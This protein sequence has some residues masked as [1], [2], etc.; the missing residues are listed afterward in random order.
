[1]LTMQVWQV[2][3]TRGKAGKKKWGRNDKTGKKMKGQGEG[4]V[5][6]RKGE[7][8]EL[9]NLEQTMRAVD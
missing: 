6:R 2:K 5:R 3:K 7:R 1:M 9:K 4:R 8:V